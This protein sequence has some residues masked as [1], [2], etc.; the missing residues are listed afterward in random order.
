MFLKVKKGILISIFF[1]IVK[2]IQSH[3][4]FGA[5]EK[6]NK[7]HQ[8]NQTKLMIIFLNAFIMIIGEIKS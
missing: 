3:D 8:Y 4:Q 6:F 2:K 5:L 1:R 7:K